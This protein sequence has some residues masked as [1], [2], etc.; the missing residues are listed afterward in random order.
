MKELA[1]A[2]G[3]EAEP[4][5]KLIY[6]QIE[7]EGKHRDRVLKI[8]EMMN[9]SMENRNGKSDGE[10]GSDGGVA[11]VAGASANAGVLGAPKANGSAVSAGLA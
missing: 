8:I 9:S 11:D 2:K 3:A 10:A 4:A 7:A 5:I 6:A 1:E